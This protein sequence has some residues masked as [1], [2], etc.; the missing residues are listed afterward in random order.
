MYETRHSPYL[1]SLA[2]FILSAC[3]SLQPKAPRLHCLLHDCQGVPGAGDEVRFVRN[4]LLK[5]ANGTNVLFCRINVRALK[6]LVIVCW[7]CERSFSGT[8]WRVCGLMKVV[9][10]VD[11]FKDVYRDTFVF[12][13]QL[14]DVYC[15]KRK[16]IFVKRHRSNSMLRP[17]IFTR[18]GELFCIWL[19]IHEGL[20][21]NWLKICS[22][23]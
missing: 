13:R 10:I 12:F 18:V 15:C 9:L 4:W 5:R 3:V 8:S 1:L 14:L 21:K 2:L 19:Y 7:I 16:K 17:Q 20:N 6:H 22:R 23:V 11:G